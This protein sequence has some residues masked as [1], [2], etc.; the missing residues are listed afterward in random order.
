[1]AIRAAL[2]HLDTGITN[3]EFENVRL[4]ELGAS[5]RLL[6]AVEEDLAAGDTALLMLGDPIAVSRGDEKLIARKLVTFHS[7]SRGESVKFDMADESDGVKRVIGLLPIFLDLR[8]GKSRMVYVV[9]ELDR[10]LH[11]LITRSLLQGFLSNCSSESRAQL[12]FTTY[13]LLLMDQDLLR[14]DEIW[15]AERTSAGG[16]S[17]TSLS[18]FKDVRYDKDIR[19]SYLQGRFGGIPR[20]VFDGKSGNVDF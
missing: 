8:A 13:D 1:D 19:K 9:D 7:N 16:T 2:A 6:A 10:S 11:T 5:K 3:V 14:R 18:E 17:L 20:V 4:E 15:A 12:L